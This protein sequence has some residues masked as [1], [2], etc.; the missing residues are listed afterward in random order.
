[1]LKIS[2]VGLEEASGH[3]AHLQEPLMKMVKFDP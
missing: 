3:S 1:M 2:C